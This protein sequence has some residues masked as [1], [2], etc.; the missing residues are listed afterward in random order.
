MDKE[1]RCGKFWRRGKMCRAYIGFGVWIIGSD[2]A[3]K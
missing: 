2:Q 1:N 3:V